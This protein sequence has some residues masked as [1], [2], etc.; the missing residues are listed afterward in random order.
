MKD[1]LTSLRKAVQRRNA[2]IARTANHIVELS[3][4]IAEGGPMVDFW[5]E[6]RQEA[7]ERLEK[8]RA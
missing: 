8:E 3:N 4:K 2:R 5:S 6:L 7:I 1:K